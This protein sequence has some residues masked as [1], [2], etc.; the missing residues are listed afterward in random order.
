MKI[1]F[2]EFY[3]DEE[4]YILE[5]NGVPVALRPKAFDLLVH[6][7]RHRRRVVL[8]EELIEQVWRTT[9]VG[10]GSLSGLVNELRQALGERAQGKS[11]I[12]TVHARGYQFVASV[13]DEEGWH[14]ELARTT[15]ADAGSHAHLASSV[16]ALVARVSSEGPQGV[17]VEHP[18]GLLC[19]VEAAGFEVL[20]LPDLEPSSRVLSSI[21]ARLMELMV[22]SLGEGAVLSALP[23]PA[24]GLLSAVAGT[25]DENAP[26][27]WIEAH[28]LGLGTVAST[29]AALARRRPVSIVF[30]EAGS[31]GGAGARELLTLCERLEGAPVLWVMSMASFET[32]GDGFR[33]LEAGGFSRW[34]AEPGA[35]ALFAQW[36]HR[37]GRESL[38]REVEDLLVSHLASDSRPVAELLGDLLSTLSESARIRR[39]RRA[40]PPSGRSRLHA[41]E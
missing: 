17:M 31:I 34:A 35:S 10:T 23:V 14:G 37:S 9:A 18:E 36:L 1:R 16:D 12:R 13:V 24:R 28:P 22:G 29:L 11:S 2:S 6:L 7:V 41:A 26:R 30:P 3:L 39:V 8:R 5:R 33:V 15:P 32:A 20:R 38:P 25:R 4:R 19:Q 21:S 40:E 27:P